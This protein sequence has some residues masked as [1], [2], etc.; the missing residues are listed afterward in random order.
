MYMGHRCITLACLAQIAEVP[1]FPVV[2]V[3]VLEEP[4]ILVC[5]VP[6]GHNDDR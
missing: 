3:A 1:S 5:S 2:V 4:H 6:H